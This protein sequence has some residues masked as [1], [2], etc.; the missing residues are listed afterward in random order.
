M[1]KKHGGLEDFVVDPF[2]FK[3]Q[4]DHDHN[5]D[6]DSYAD[7][8]EEDELMTMILI[9]KIMILM[10]MMMMLLNLINVTS[11]VDQMVGSPLLEGIPF[12][13]RCRHH[14]LKYLLF[15]CA[16]ISTG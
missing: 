10:I 11:C 8:N 3:Y 13:F 4:V 5:H 2:G 9:T 7:G 16:S 12:S 14:A 6:H 1:I 15:R